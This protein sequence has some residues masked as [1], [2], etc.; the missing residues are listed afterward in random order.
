M[1]YLKDAIGTSKN[2]AK[3]VSII[4]VKLFMMLILSSPGT[5]LMRLVILRQTLL[6]Q[7]MVLESNYRIIFEPNLFFTKT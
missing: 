5:A 1:L 6:E 2:V 3:S 4:M 7:G